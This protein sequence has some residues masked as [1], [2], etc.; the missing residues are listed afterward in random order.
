MFESFY[1]KEWVQ[2][3]T[4]FVLIIAI[5]FTPLMY[6]RIGRGLKGDFKKQFIEAA[7]D[8]YGVVLFLLIAPAGYL[9]LYFFGSQSKFMLN[10]PMAWV[11]FVGGAASIYDLI[12]AR[13]TLKS[14]NSS[15]R[16]NE[17]I[18]SIFMYERLTKLAICLS[19]IPLLYGMVMIGV[20]NLMDPASINSML[21]FLTFMITGLAVIYAVASKTL[22]LVSQAYASN[23][24]LG[25]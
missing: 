13:L 4:A 20:T 19:L 14:A 10:D 1:A 21:W 16:C 3:S 24:E 6:W 12:R 15:S 9:I 25:C 22:L 23:P 8:I 5:L 17:R 7:F 2:V 11:C 18:G